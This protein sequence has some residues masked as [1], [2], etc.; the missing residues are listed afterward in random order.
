M[1]EETRSRLGRGLA[2][3]MGDVGSETNDTDRGR[4]GTKKVPTE[5]L[6]PN[7]RNPRKTFED[8]DLEELTASIREKG[9]IQPIV[10][11][12]QAGLADVYEIIAGERRWRA[13][14]R[15]G[16][17]EV[18]I[19]VIEASD[20]DALELAIIE[21]VQR[22]DLNPIEEAAG[23]ERLMAEFDYAQA[24]LGKMIG[25]SRSH[26]A[27]TL[28]LMKLPDSVKEMLRTG[29]LSA[30]HGRAL[31]AVDNPEQIA[32]LAIE[33]GSSV[34]DLEKLS[35]QPDETGSSQTRSGSEQSQKDADTRAIEKIL[36]DV[37]GMN[38]NISHAGQGGELKIRYKTLDQLEDLCQRLRR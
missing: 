13:A 38:V 7:A 23:Y 9:I 15:A 28:R 29:Q 4:S 24:D 34:R 36:E 8:H 37:L 26:I 17:H 30:G 19:I 32:K 1:A 33:R 25:K 14:Q 35:R 5:F 10:V 3:L 20:R 16:L 12:E 18:P 27:N 31:L 22:A 21:N 6:R 11:R 2:A